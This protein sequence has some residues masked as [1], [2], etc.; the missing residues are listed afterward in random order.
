MPR[1][2]ALAS[3]LALFVFAAGVQT[4]FALAMPLLIA[5][6]RIWPRIAWVGVLLLWLS[7]IAAAAAIHAVIGRLIVATAPASCDDWLGGAASWWAG[8][9]AWASIIVVSTTM[10]LVTVV[11][12]P[13]PI[14]DPHDVW[15]LVAAATGS[16]AGSAHALIWILLA[17]YVYELELRAQKS[18]ASG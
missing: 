1:P 12:H 2:V 4:A 10:V 3:G 16:G 5:L 14:R 18:S 15:I 11:L 6:M 9:V 13:P 17:A 8:F 7:P